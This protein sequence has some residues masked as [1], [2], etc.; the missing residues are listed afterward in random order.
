MEAEE[1]ETRRQGEGHSRTD[2]SN[3]GEFHKPDA[4]YESKMT[5]THFLRK[6]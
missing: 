3:I 2:E 1:E 6:A 4:I 5:K